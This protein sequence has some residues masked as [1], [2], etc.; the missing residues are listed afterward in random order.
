MSSVKVINRVSIIKRSLDLSFVRERLFVTKRYLPLIKMSNNFIYLHGKHFKHATIVVF[1]EP[2]RREL[3]PRPL[4]YH[5]KV[6]CYRNEMKYSLLGFDAHESVV[7]LAA[8][9]TF[10]D[11]SRVPNWEIGDI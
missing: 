9:A 1:I 11:T 7:S 6:G 2:P 3:N 5:Y 8:G 10:G 4:R